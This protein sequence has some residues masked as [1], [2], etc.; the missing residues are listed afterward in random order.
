MPVAPPRTPNAFVCTPSSLLA[1]YPC[2]DCLSE[3]QIRA[4]M[5]GIIGAAIGKT[6][7]E[8]MRESACF[9]CM[10]DKQK[11]EAVAV[12]LG[13]SLL[14]EN[15]SPQQIIDDYKCLLCATPDQINAALTYALCHLITFTET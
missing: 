6:A 11:L 10:S 13:N 2:V 15:H 12:I 9:T 14:G 4:F 3:S 5:V 1:A 8:M 7:A